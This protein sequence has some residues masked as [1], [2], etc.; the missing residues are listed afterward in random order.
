VWF[1]ELSPAEQAAVAA[2]GAGAAGGAAY[3]LGGDRIQTPVNM[4][5]RMAR[6][7]AK[8][9]L[10]GT[11]RARILGMLRRRRERM[12]WRAIR[13]WLL[14]LRK[15]ATRSY[16]RS[17]VADHRHLATRK[18]LRTE[19][20]ARLGAVRTR[21]WRGWLRSNL[22]A[23]VGSIAGGIVPVGLIGEVLLP[24]L[25]VAVDE[26]QRWVE[27]QLFDRIDRFRRRI[28]RLRIQLRA[29]VRDVRTE[30]LVALVPVMRAVGAQVVAWS[31]RA[32]DPALWGLVLAHV[33]VMG[34]AVIIA[35]VERIVMLW[36]H[37]PVGLDELLAEDDVERLAAAQIT[38]VAQLAAVGDADLQ[39]VL[40]V[41]AATVDRWRAAADDGR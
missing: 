31:E 20:E 26:L 28:E 37:E 35:I 40:S 1:G 10:R 6:S 8:R 39:R 13:R 30:G 21:K 17:W 27:D 34:A 11:S 29:I 7:W 33:R 22:R 18:G 14:G 4:A 2:G 23:Q 24:A 41:G 19:L 15:Y 38:T 12:S 36:G 16:W 32:R 25:R 3:T 9:K 5:Q